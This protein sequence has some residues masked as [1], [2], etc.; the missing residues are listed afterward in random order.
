MV[1]MSS[2]RARRW[3]PDKCSDGDPT[4][5][6]RTDEERF[7]T[8]TLD[9]GKVVHIATVSLFNLMI[10]TTNAPQ[11]KVFPDP[12]SP[13]LSEAKMLISNSTSETGVPAEGRN[14]QKQYDQ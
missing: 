5:F 12:H 9:F 2:V 7:P 10:L 14:V 11:V 4:N 3:G 8:I 13:E 6:C 1:T